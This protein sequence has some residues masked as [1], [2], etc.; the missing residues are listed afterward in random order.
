MV[1]A[2]KTV[3]DVPED[4]VVL[5]LHASAAAARKKTSDDNAMQVDAPADSSIPALPSVLALCVTYT[6]S[7]PALRLAIRQH[8]SDAGEL[9]LILQ[10]L[11]QW[12]DTWCE[13]DVSLQIGRAHV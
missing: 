4:D 13:E 11:K 3:I 1:L 5:L 8:I 12:I 10:I 6:M 9:T 7:A 2:L